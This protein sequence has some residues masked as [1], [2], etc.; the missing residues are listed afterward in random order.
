MKFDVNDALM[1]LGYL[2]LVAGVAAWYWPAGLVLLGLG[3]L[4]LGVL[5]ELGVINSEHPA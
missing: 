4:A 5:R 2:V 3:L 1:I